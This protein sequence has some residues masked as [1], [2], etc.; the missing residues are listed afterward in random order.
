MAR[1]GKIEKVTW[2]SNNNLK[3]KKGKRGKKLRG[4]TDFVSYIIYSKNSNK[5]KGSVELRTQW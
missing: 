3:G 1:E 4:K 5:V 2:N